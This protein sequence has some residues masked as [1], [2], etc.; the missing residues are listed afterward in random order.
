MFLQK[1][2]SWFNKENAC[3]IFPTIKEIL[4]SIIASSQ[5]TTILR[6]FNYT[7]LFMRHCIYSNKLNSMTIS[8]HEFN[9]KVIIKYNLENLSYSVIIRF[10]EKYSSL[11]KGAKCTNYN[12]LQKLYN[13]FPILI[14]R[15]NTDNF[16]FSTGH[17]PC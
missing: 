4:F 6:K 9:S 15:N 5:D 3:Q 12:N 2:V 1:V 17:L 8:I 16:L 7:T 13:S 11:L 10:I 14:F